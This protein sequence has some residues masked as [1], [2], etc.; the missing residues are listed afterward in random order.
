MYQVLQIVYLFA[1]LITISTT[2]SVAA[3]LIDD[4]SLIKKISLNPE[5]T[6]TEIQNIILDTSISPKRRAELKVLLAEVAYYID[7]PEQ[8]LKYSNQSLSSGLLSNKWQVKALINQARAYS[9]TKQFERCNIAANDAVQLAEQFNLP[10]QR[11]AALI[12]RAFSYAFLDKNIQAENDIA[13]ASRYLK[14]L[15]DNFTKGILLDRI[16]GVNHTLMRNQLA[17]TE[18]EAA[19]IIYQKIKAS[20]FLSIAFYNLSG[21]HQSQGDLIQAAKNMQLSY[22]WALKE[23]NKLNQ[24]FSLNRLAEYK[25]LLGERGAAKSHLVA[26]MKIADQTASE[27]VKVLVRIQMAKFLFEENETI[28]S[29]KLITATITFARQHGLF[30][31]EIELKRML[32][33]IYYHQKKFEKAYLLLKETL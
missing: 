26:A 3:Q 15:P 20:H 10:K 6:F 9:Q 17:L 29:E 12:E 16:S 14:V 23:S 2:T 1:L 19:I 21:I 32:A 31:D 7:Q 33:K 8:T 13:L 11:I 30:V 18:Q 27:R 5:Q 4:S 25:L 24:A 22:D 28:A